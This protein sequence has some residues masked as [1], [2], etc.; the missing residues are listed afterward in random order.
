MAAKGVDS[1]DVE[2]DK[3]DAY[4]GLGGLARKEMEREVER[5]GA[6]GKTGRQEGD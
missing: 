1:S 6:T 4:V 2:T 5:I 3:I